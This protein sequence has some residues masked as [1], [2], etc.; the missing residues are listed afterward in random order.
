MERMDF[1][2]NQSQRS[3]VITESVPEDKGETW[4]TSEMKVQ[5][6]Q[7]DKLGLIVNRSWIKVRHIIVKLLHYKN[8]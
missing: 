5:E 8:K 7:G 2:E 3:I 6:I 1:L 4:E